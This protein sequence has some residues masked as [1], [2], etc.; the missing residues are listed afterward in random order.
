MIS[1]D[2]VLS[3]IV[4]AIWEISSK[5][6]ANI[7]G[8]GI[9]YSPQIELGLTFIEIYILTFFHAIIYYH[10]DGHC[11]FQRYFYLNVTKRAYICCF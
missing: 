4:N 6:W 9:M 10:D 5:C 11:F 1:P 3:I 8:A 7:C 2:I